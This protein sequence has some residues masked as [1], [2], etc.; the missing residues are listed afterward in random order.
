MKIIIDNNNDNNKKRN[1]I[2]IGTKIGLK[3]VG[4]GKKSHPRFDEILMIIVLI[5]AVVLNYI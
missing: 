1:K 2:M 5:G 4:W 3:T